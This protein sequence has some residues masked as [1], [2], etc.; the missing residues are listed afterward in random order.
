[1]GYWGVVNNNI[2][3][4]DVV[5]LVM[6]ARLPEETQNSEVEKKVDSMGKDLR[7]IFNKSDLISEKDK[8]KLRKSYPDAFFVSAKKQGSL[9]N[10]INILE[11]LGKDR[12]KSLRVAIIGYPNVGKSSLL[13][14]LAPM[15]RV[16]VSSVSGTTKKTEWVRSGELRFMDTPGVIPSTDSKVQIGIT[17]SKDPHKIPNPEKVAYRVIRTIRRKDDNILKR[18]FG[19][20]FDSEDRD[21]EVFE[22][23]GKHKKFL[24]KGGEVDDHRTA[25]KII[26]DWQKGKISMK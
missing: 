11:E 21:Y 26:D 20:E 15:A 3:N 5:L 18:H 16:K 9:T 4:A 6:D 25:V 7:F 8:E 12:E 13:N 2:K 24:I 22:K 1:M 17:A 14:I 23:I 10:I 19:V